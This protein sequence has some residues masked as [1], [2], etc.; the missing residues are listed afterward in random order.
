MWEESSLPPPHGHVISWSE[1]VHRR[2]RAAVLYYKHNE[3]QIRGTG[4]WREG[5]QDHGRGGVVKM[6]PNTSVLTLSAATTH[7]HKHGR[8]QMNLKCRLAAC[9]TASRLVGFLHAK[10]HG[11]HPSPRSCSCSSVG[12]VTPTSPMVPQV[13]Q[14]SQ[15]PPHHLKGDMKQ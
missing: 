10:A 14:T 11:K 3:S 12:W 13:A 7:N 4:N 5:R 9:A 6:T 1:W 8:G 15:C 2:I